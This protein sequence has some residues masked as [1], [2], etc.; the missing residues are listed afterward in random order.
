MDVKPRHT[1]NFRGPVKN[2]GLNCG[3]PNQPIVEGKRAS[4]GPAAKKTILG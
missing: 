4:H 1:H 3:K 2:C